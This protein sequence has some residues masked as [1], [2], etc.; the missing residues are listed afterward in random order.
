MICFKNIEKINFKPP[1]FVNI[2]YNFYL[3]L[4]PHMLVAKGKVGLYESI[5]LASLDTSIFIKIG[6][7]WNSETYD[8]AFLV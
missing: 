6:Y 4:N 5:P 7:H 2:L 1:I 8:P 3:Y